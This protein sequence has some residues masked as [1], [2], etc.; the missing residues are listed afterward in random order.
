MKIT[1][2]AILAIIGSFALIIAGCGEE[3]GPI[4]PPPPAPPEY[5]DKHMPAGWWADEK[6][7][8]E[9]DRKSTRLNSSHGYISYAV[10]CLKKKNSSSQDTH[11]TLSSPVG[12]SRQDAEETHIG[13]RHT[14]R[15][16]VRTYTGG[17]TA[18]VPRSTKQHALHW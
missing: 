1:S 11:G 13:R 14:R 12:C 8:A 18:V 3:E 4:Q 9:G 6:I 15:E 2:L 16:P 17:S 5:A 7:I 10:F